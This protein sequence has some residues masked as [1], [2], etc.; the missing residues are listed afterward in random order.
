MKEIDG[1]PIFFVKF[2][3]RALNLIFAQMMGLRV[4][5]TEKCMG[6]NLFSLNKLV[7]FEKNFKTASPIPN[8]C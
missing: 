5:F 6:Q 8:V 4:L 1:A 2:L 3:S 7:N